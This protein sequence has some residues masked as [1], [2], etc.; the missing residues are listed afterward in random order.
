MKSAAVV[1]AP[2]PGVE[3]LIK[4]A[5][6]RQR[7]RYAATGVAVGTVLA[8]VLGAFA[9]LHGASGPPRASQP[10]PAAGHRPQV[11]GPI[12]ASADTTVLMWPG[13][14]D[15]T[16]NLDNLRTGKI[17]R[18][19]PVADPGQNQPIMLVSGWIVYISNDSVRAT[20]AVTGKTRGSAKRW[21][22]P[23]RHAWRSLA[24]VR[25]LPVVGCVPAVSDRMVARQLVA[26]LPGTRSAD[27]GLPGDHRAGAVVHPNVLPV[28]RN[29]HDH[30]PARLMRW[31][32]Q[33]WRA[34]HSGGASRLPAVR[35]PNRLL[36]SA[37]AGRIP[38]A[39]GE[40]TV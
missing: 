28:R 4:E 32:R 16:I 15:G 24:R 5:R 40:D 22:S 18:A 12:P 29:G 27:V 11:P 17:G 2:A 3:A 9:G 36:A 38:R 39:T 14:Q 26:V 35:M 6:R 19:T 34:D 7:R 30:Q 13:D 25:L 37:C 20:D 8:A 31:L 23:V 1:P 33:R 10:R 21:H